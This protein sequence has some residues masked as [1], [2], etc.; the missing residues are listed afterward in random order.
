MSTKEFRTKM[1]L[2][3]LSKLFTKPHAKECKDV[4]SLPVKKVLVVAPHADDEV[5]GCGAAIDHFVRS[6][7]QVTVL[8]V[9]QESDK[10]IAK[11]YDYTAKERIK[12]SQRAKKILGYQELIYFDFPELGLRDKNR[13]QVDFGQQ[14][15]D[16]IFKIRPNA[17]FIPNEKEMHPDHK[18]VGSV[19][20]SI[21][22]EGKMK[23]WFNFLQFVLIYEVWGPVFMNSFLKVNYNAKRKKKRSIDCYASQLSSVDYNQIMEFVGKRRASDLKA[24]PKDP[25]DV[26]QQLAEAYTLY[27]EHDLLHGNKVMFS[28]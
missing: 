21:I 12:E 7:A 15:Q 20:L 23:G 26:R 4:A 24:L 18:V 25:I 16:L 22:T 5:I 1:L 10:S 17:V 6:G 14:L 2:G 3:Q 9:T 11:K 8:I 13:L 27:E 19:A 28:L